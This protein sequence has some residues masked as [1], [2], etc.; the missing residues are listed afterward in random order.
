MREILFLMAVLVAPV[1]AQDLD[2]FV[3]TTYPSG[4]AVFSGGR[5]VAITQ[6]GLVVKSGSLFLTTTGLY[7]SCGNLYYGNGNLTV[8]DRDISYGTAGNMRVRDGSYYAGNNGQT[9]IYDSDG[10]E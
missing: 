1:M 2:D 10:S 7:A 9:Y 8:V 3:G 5:G 4:N 6:N